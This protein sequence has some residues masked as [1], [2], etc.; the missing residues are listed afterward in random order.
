MSNQIQNPYLKLACKIL[1]GIGTN[2]TYPLGVC[3]KTEPRG[4][5]V[6]SFAAWVVAGT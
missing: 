6:P 2:L 3:R 5:F 1:A 4:D